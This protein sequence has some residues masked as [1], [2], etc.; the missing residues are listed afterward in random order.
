MF[1]CNYTFLIIILGRFNVDIFKLKVN[2]ITFNILSRIFV[3]WK[4]ILYIA[5][6]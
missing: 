6:F 3:K 5:A 1:V 2:S 4:N